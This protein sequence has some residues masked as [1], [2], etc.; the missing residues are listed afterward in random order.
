MSRE[1]QHFVVDLDEYHLWTA[2]PLGN[3]Q[4]AKPNN[5]H[6]GVVGQPCQNDRC[7]RRFSPPEPPSRLRAIAGQDFAA[8]SDTGF[9][10]CSPRDPFIHLVFLRVRCSGSIDLAP[11][12]VTS[13]G[14]S[15]T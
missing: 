4:A 3:P 7:L 1:I 2:D 6:V 5:L 14:E 11:D 9:A 10:G 12:A 13:P 8:F 15:P